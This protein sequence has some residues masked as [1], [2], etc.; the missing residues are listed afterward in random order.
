[1]LCATRHEGDIN[2]AVKKNGH[3]LSNGFILHSYSI[4]LFGFNKSCLSCADTTNSTKPN[5]SVA[6]SAAVPPCSNGQAT[7]PNNSTSFRSLDQWSG[8]R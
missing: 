4:S 1:M 6:N 2:A 7:L 3:H 5:G 8:I